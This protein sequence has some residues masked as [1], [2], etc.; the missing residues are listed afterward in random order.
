MG[1]ELITFKK[2]KILVKS[3]KRINAWKL[4]TLIEQWIKES[5][6]A[7]ICID[8]L[9]NS[10]VDRAALALW[11]LETIKCLIMWAWL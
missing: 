11:T 2:F 10:M 5:K 8:K 3:I 6:T 4:K 9:Y 1:F 7:P